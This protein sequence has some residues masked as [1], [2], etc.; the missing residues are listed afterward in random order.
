MPILPL[1]VSFIFFIDSII[2]N[3][4][5]FDNSLAFLS[6][7]SNKLNINKTNESANIDINEIMAY[8]ASVANFNTKD[9]KLDV[10]DLYDFDNSILSGKRYVDN[11]IDYGEAVDYWLKKYYNEITDKNK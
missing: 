7:N 2:L 5:L 3:S 9:N 11:S 10:A 6:D 1:Q 4:S 8:F